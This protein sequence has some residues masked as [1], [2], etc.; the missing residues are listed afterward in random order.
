LSTDIPGLLSKIGVPVPDGD[1]DKLAAAAAAWQKFATS[2]ALGDA[3]NLTML[4]TFQFEHI[5]SPEVPDIQDHLSAL[6][7]CAQRIVQAANQLRIDCAD[8]VDALND[9]RNRL[10]E[11][12][13]IL[14][15]LLAA[16]IVVG[17]LATLITAGIS[18]EAATAAGAAEIA[19]TADEMNTAIVAGRLATLLKKTWNGAKDLLS[20]RR[21]LDTIKNL[22]KQDAEEDSSPD[23][24]PPQ[25]RNPASTLRQELD[26]SPTWTEGNMPTKDG[27]PGG[28]FVKRDSDGNITNYTQYDENGNGIKRVDLTGDAHYDKSTGTY[29]QTPHT[30]DIVQNIN[31]RTGE[32]FPRT[33]PSTV[34]PASPEEI[35]R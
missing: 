10:K 8:H 15:A 34:R 29:I 2:D 17:V 5:Q 4:G 12:L 13:H 30:V 21:L 25:P 26:N 27:P 7:N 32:I 33:D 1:T 6:G 28:Y 11:L 31:P 22:Q 24:K 18:D 20:I 9:L 23:V 3:S 16:D 19:E 14:E 35:P